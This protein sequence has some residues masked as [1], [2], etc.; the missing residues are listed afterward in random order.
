MPHFALTVVLALLTMV[1]PLGIDAYLPSIPAIAREFGATDLLVQQTLSFYVGGMSVMML[2]YGTLSDSYGRRPVVLVSLAL[3]C[4]ASVAAAL[5]PG[6]VPLIVVRALQGL[7]GG[8]GTIIARAMVQDRFRG[9]E[10]QRMMAMITMVFGVAPALAPII[11][12]WLEATLGWRWVFAFLALFAAA[13][14]FTSRAVLAET[15]PP[16]Q[17]MPFRPGP[18]AASYRRLLSEPR[19]MLRVIGYAFVF[20]GVGLYVGSAPAFMMN[21]LHQPPTAFA[22]LFIPLVSGIMSGS[23]V[24]GRLSGRVG[25]DRL[26]RAGFAIM[27]CA[28]AINVAYSALADVRLPYAVMPMFVFTFGMSLA[29]PGMTVLSLSVF[30]DMRGLAAAM[31]GFTQM[32]VFALISGLLAPQLF[33]SALHIA[34]GHAAGLAIGIAAWS[35]GESLRPRHR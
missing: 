16:E 8:A 18:I 13:M 14:W 10:A 5:A 3:Y 2:F 6:V 25:P 4:I 35:A 9:H 26:I 32:M 23:A 7:C 11:G 28:V 20:S 29:A 12:G 27:V 30:S 22:W 31:Q 34:L 15:L 19:F 1:G 21:I 33:D 17:R 24:A